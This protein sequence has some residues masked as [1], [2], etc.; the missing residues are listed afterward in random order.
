MN[1]PIIDFSIP[2]I[3]FDVKDIDFFKYDFD[4]KNTKFKEVKKELHKLSRGY[5]MYCYKQISHI[6]SAHKEHYI[7][8]SKMEKFK[9]HQY[10]IVYSCPICNSIKN[11]NSIRDKYESLTKKLKGNCGNCSLTFTSKECYDYNTLIYR[12]VSGIINPVN[13][14]MSEY[15]EYSLILKR[16]VAKHPYEKRGNEHIDK[17]LSIDPEEIFN[18]VSH[19]IKK[20]SVILDFQDIPYKNLISLNVVEYFKTL[21]N[22]SGIEGVKRELTVLETL[23]YLKN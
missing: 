13:Y 16:F 3:D 11:R 7:D 21:K 4:K 17:M 1:V 10:N 5:C 19:I 2:I 6:E 12:Y 20:H 15:I 18:S 8:K 22:K 23:D 14:K 9:S